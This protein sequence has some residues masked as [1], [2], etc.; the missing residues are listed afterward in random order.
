MRV[1][2]AIAIKLDDGSIGWLKESTWMGMTPD[3]WDIILNKCDRTLFCQE[4]QAMAI[5]KCVLVA[6]SDARPWMCHADIYNL[7]KIVR[8]KVK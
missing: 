5:A 3:Y 1:K 8:C 6:L 2:Y 7:I 4:Y